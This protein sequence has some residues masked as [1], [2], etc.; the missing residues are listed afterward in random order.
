MKTKLALAAAALSLAACNPSQP[1]KAPAA[2]T[3]T[4]TAAVSATDAWCRPSPNGA[5]AGGCYVTL[6]AATDDRLT[7]GSTPRAASLQVHEM[8][9]ENG[10][11][12]MAELTAGLPLPAGQA[13]ALAPGGNHLMLIGLTAPLV[14]GE[15]VPLTFQFAS[16]P[17]ITVQ[18]QVRQPAMDG[19][20]HSA[21]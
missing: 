18:A 9:T 15:T 17:A 6:T 10:M 8:K 5:K 16:A 7:G 1:A 11:M 19:M 14:A 2:E 13:V 21:H 3:P 4:A 20:D 12:K